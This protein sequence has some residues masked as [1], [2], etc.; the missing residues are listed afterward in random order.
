MNINGKQIMAIVVAVLGVIIASTAQLT[1]IFGPGPTKYIISGAS[2]LNSVLATVLSVISSQ[3]GLVSDVQAMRGVEKV[4][5][6][7]LA[8]QTLAGMAIDPSQ[9]KIET[10]PGDEHV[11]NATANG[12]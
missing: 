5:V 8:N 9:S 12:S 10:K 11:V 6:N 2:L 4:V 7:R 1:D 3:A